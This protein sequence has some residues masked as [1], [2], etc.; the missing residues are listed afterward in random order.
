MTKRLLSV[1]CVSIVVIMENV[2][3]SLAMEAARETAE[4]FIDFISR[5]EWEAHHAHGGKA[6]SHSQQH[7]RQQEQATASPAA[8]DHDDDDDTA[9]DETPVEP[10]ESSV[11]HAAATWNDEP[12]PVPQNIYA[13]RPS[14][15]SPTGA[16]AAKKRR[17]PRAD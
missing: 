15:A 7:A 6:A 10:A 14:E 1:C 5:K 3:H 4:H 17:P 13:S 11:P 12:E 8:Y 2:G 16:G 9:Q